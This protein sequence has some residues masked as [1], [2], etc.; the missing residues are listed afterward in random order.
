MTRD[1]ALA[2]I[3]ATEADFKLPGVLSLHLADIENGTVPHEGAFPWIA[4]A[5]SK[6]AVALGLP[7]SSRELLMSLCANAMRASFETVMGS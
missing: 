2:A 5:L 7:E 3:R 4:Y 1:E 6:D